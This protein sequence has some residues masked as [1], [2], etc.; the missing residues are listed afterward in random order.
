MLIGTPLNERRK[1]RAFWRVFNG[2]QNQEDM[3]VQ[4]MWRLGAWCE[5][6]DPG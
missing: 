1:Y 3:C 5:L 2:D 6:N 4:R